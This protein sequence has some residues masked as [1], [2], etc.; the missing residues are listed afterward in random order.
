VQVLRMLAGT[1][2]HVVAVMTRDSGA[3]AVGATVAGVA[4]RLGYSV[5]PIQRA[6]EHGFAQLLTAKKLDLILNVHAHEILPPAVVA[7][8]RIGSFNLHPGPLPAYAGLNAPSWAIYHGQTGHGVTLHW[9]DEGIASGP[10]A[11]SAEFPIEDDD[12][13]LTLSAKCIRASLPLIHDLLQDAARNIVPRHPQTR[14]VRRYYGQE[15]PHEG[16]LIWTERAARIVNFVRACDYA[17]FASPWG[18]P[19]A[20]LIGREI[21]VLKAAQSGARCNAPAG[22]IGNREGG[23]IL[24]AARDEWVRVRRVQVGS[25]AYSASDVLRSGEQFVLPPV[26]VPGSP[27]VGR[28]PA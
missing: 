21:V 20:Y 9:M 11:Y 15:I 10:V 12:T 8:P 5:W 28:S 26:E 18:R 14:H 6:R 1:A 27:L 22:M 4:S 23:D 25:T 2:H 16:R 24:V 17:P 7:A 3:G 19:R 13:G